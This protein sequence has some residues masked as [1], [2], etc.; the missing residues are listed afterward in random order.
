[1]KSLAITLAVLAVILLY[2]GI[3]VNMRLQRQIRADATFPGGKI[4][5]TELRILENNPGFR[6]AKNIRMISY[7]LF[8]VFGGASAY[9]FYTSS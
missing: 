2:V 1:M 3:Y 7:G 5:E 6:M 9:F 8:V 4:N